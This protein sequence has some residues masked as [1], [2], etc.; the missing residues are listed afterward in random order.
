MQA[1]HRTREEYI[2]RK[3]S[4]WNEIHCLLL[5]RG[6]EGVKGYFFSE[7]KFRIS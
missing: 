2:K 5:E 6:I 4:I 7:P 3:T 1:I